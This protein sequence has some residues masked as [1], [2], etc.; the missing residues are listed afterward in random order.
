MDACGCGTTGLKTSGA[1]LWMNEGQTPD[2]QE[3]PYA[4]RASGACVYVAPEILTD[5][6]NDASDASSRGLISRVRRP[7]TAGRPRHATHLERR[8]G[9]GSD[10]PLTDCY[11]VT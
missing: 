2:Q 3:A 4:V 8:P 6:A 1:L 10:A 11:N 7:E 5:A 9:L